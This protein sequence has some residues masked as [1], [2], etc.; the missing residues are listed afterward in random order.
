MRSSIRRV[1]VMSHNTTMFSHP[2]DVHN[3][4]SRDAVKLPF[5]GV[6]VKTYILTV[7][8]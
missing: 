8:L 1:P 7:V 3:N 6:K 2:N 4:L 5:I